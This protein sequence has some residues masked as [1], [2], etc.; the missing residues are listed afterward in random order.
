MKFDSKFFCCMLCSFLLAAGSVAQVYADLPEAVGDV[1]EIGEAYVFESPMT[2]EVN[3]DLSDYIR[4]QTYNIQCS[5]LKLSPAYGNTISHLSGNNGISYYPNRYPYVDNYNGGEFIIVV[6][7]DRPY[8]AD[9]VGLNADGTAYGFSGNI[10]STVG[11][12]IYSGISR[13]SDTEFRVSCIVN[14]PF[15]LT[16][17]ESSARLSFFLKPAA[18]PVDSTVSITF[19]FNGYTDTVS[20]GDGGGGDGGG[21]SGSGGGAAT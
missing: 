20:E 8:D 7:Y 10:L 18:I 15:T 17:S 16:E 19:Y 1:E 3:S 21:G 9:A 14:K 12:Q 2:F 6:K 5:D 4:M 13:I 11:S